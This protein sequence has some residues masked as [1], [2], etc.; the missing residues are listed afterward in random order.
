MR[1]RILLL[2]HSLTAA[3]EN[4]LYCGSTDLPLSPAGIARA[5]ETAK[6]WGYKAEDF[7]SYFTSGMQRTDE[8]L[9]L[10]F[11]SIPFTPF[12]ALREL[13]F[14]DFEMQ[15]YEQ[16][17]DRP[18]YQRWITGDNRKNRC[19]RGE[20]AEDMKARCLPAFAV[21]MEQESAVV[22]SHGGVIAEI[23]AH[24]F[25]WEEKTRYLWQPEPAGGYLLTIENG[26]P[27][28]YQRAF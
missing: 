2:R 27:T 12:P 7:A 4:R 9:R 21:P 24:Y 23:M 25:P 19:P 10:L 5:K 6:S 26:R 3:N 1:G 16:L 8:T 17:K 20:S 14:G 28:A 13:D 15:S 22:V 11:G 18:D